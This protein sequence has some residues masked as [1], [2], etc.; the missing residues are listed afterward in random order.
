M[1]YE[2]Q[3]QTNIDKNRIQG[4]SDRI[5]IFISRMENVMYMNIRIQHLR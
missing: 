2:H 3:S 4:N 1:K 5:M